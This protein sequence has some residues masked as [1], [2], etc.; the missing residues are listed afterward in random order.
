MKKVMTLLLVTAF[1]L[2][3]NTSNV[4]AI[5]TGEEQE[6]PKDGEYH[7][8][9]KEIEV[10]TDVVNTEDKEPYETTMVEVEPVLEKTETPELIDVAE[11]QTSVSIF[12]V[13]S[14]L[15]ILMG[16]CAILFKRKK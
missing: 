5:Y 1:T 12:Y 2:L 8:M 16:V 7:I 15:V 9:T 14:G 3:L 11:E 10:S 13:I 4:F 6:E